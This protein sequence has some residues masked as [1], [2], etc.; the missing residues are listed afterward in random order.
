MQNGS[1]AR[2]GTSFLASPDVL[3]LMAAPRVGV[4]SSHCWW[5][6]PASGRNRGLSLCFTKSVKSWLIRRKRRLHPLRQT[7]H[8][9]CATLISIPDSRPRWS[10]GMD[11]GQSPDLMEAF[12]TALPWATSSDYRQ[13]RTQGDVPGVKNRDAWLL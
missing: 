2:R 4:R 11:G 6:R 7:V 5:V 13:M 9:R 3:V 8:G 12:A 10:W 1:V